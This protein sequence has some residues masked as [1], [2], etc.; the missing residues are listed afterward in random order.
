MAEAKRKYIKRQHGP[1]TIDDARKMARIKA[2]HAAPLWGL[3]PKKLSVMC[4]RD[5]VA[6][7]VKIGR[8]YFVTPAGMDAIFNT[9]SKRRAR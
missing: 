7:A 6:D 2:V 1:A 9:K 4:L 5:E 8:D 3:N